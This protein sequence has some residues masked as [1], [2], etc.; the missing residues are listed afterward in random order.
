MKNLEEALTHYQEL[1]ARVD[2]L[3]TEIRSR[4]QESM[5]CTLGC[6]SCCKPELTVGPLEAENIRRN[7][8]ENQRVALL[9]Q[10]KTSSFQGSRCAFLQENGACGIYELRPLVCRSHGV[11]LQFQEIMNGISTRYRDVCP[12]NFPVAL[13]N[14]ADQDVMNLDTL[15]TILATLTAMAHGKE[16]KRIPLRPSAL[17]PKLS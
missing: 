4:N 3:F 16:Y 9:R 6:H 2:E 17:L 1:L 10:E 8:P 13:E 5:Q 12:L 14:L 15:N 7:I 11:P